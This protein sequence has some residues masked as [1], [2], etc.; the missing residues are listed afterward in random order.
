M[1]RLREQLVLRPNLLNKLKHGLKHK[2][3][4]VSAPAGFGKTTLISEWA[5]Q[6][7]IA[8]AWFSVGD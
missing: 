3:I 8:I 2:L 4:L 7:N 1:P 6:Q 5:Y